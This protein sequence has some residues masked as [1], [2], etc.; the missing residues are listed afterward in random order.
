M[1]KATGFLEFPR[2]NEAYE[3]PEAR[4]KHYK[5]FVFAL[6]DNEA[7]IQGARCMDCGIP[8][9]NNGCPV[10]NIIPDFND[11]VYRQDWKTAIEVLHST[12]NFPEF[13]GR[14]C[15]APCEAACTLGINELPVGIKS[16]E[17]AIIDKAWKEGWVAPQV[18]KHKTGKTVAVV[19][20]GPAGMAA[21]QQLARAGHDVTLFE[22]ND[23][24]GGLLR[25]GIPDFKLEKAQID[26]RMQQMEA[27]GVT[28]RT[29]VMVGDKTVPAG[30]AN[31]AR[32]TI[33][34]EEILKQ[35]DAVV[36]TGGSEVPR[37]L[38]VPG[39]DLDGV[40]YALEFLIPQNKEVAGDAPNP[41]RADGKHV[42]VI[43][44]GDT[45]SDCVGTSNRHGAASVTQFEL[46]PRPPEEENKPLVWPYWP[47]KLRTSS[48]HDEG[49][50]RD[51]S[52]ATK[53]LIGE[54]G[55]VT[56]L[57]A[58]RL[59]WKDGKMSE[60]AGSEFTLKADLVLL[61]M[62][63]TNPVG[64]VLDAFGVTKDARN[65]ARASTEGD[66]AYATNVP[67]VFAAG[68]VRRGQSLVVWAIREGRQAARAV[69]AF[70][71]GHSELPR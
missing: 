53:A 34:A 51:W 18:P 9:C 24:I 63:F 46:L 12:N 35:F 64:G 22:K 25:Y 17:H 1:G 60:V 52:V 30:I 28:F 13:T 69:D 65:N 71:M 29:G 45:G 37:D 14:I 10:N 43:G 48:S 32:E 23:R 5:E 67:K 40:H 16:I 20:S 2:Q 55:R 57:T 21:A 8:F 70:L 66:N 61:A 56:G 58:V 47:I 38:P 44:G 3:A 26:R 50:E 7:K 4:V 15:P 11:L 42:I 33:A 31:D 68:D 27:E 59:E 62:G 49:C 39:R 54:N 41:I 19:G 6:A 36:L